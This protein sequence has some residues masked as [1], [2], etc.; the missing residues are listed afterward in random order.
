MTDTN[1]RIGTI[2]FPMAKNKIYPH[3]SW[4][5]LS[6][7][8]TSLPRAKT[9]KSWRAS[10]PGH[11]TFSF[12]LPRYLFETPPKGTPLP[13]DANGYGG[14]KATQENRQLL[15]KTLQVA[16]ILTSDILVLS[17]PAEFTPAK[18]LVDALGELLTA[19]SLEGRTI[20]WQPQ[21]PWEPEL[22][23]RTAERLNLLLAVDPLRDPA[24]P[25]DLAYF[26]LGPFAAMGSR[27][28]V[29]DL[30]RLVEA[31]APFEKTIIVFETPRALDDVRNLK[32]VL[33]EGV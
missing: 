7:T 30:E 19:V 9:A 20:V 23:M 28:G 21:G 26:R 15:E 22:A 13:G 1:C 12:Q 25:G 2:G 27:V 10:A 33:E 6:D 18:P 8:Y 17:T 31:A 14:F 16:D 24:P 29:Y 5:E 3:V 11:V 32:K 4:V